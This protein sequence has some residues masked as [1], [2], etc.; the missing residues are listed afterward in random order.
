MSAAQELTAKRKVALRQLLAE[1][2]ETFVKGRAFYQL[3]KP[4]TIQDYKDIIVRRRSDGELITGKE[5]I[6]RGS[7][8]QRVNAA[9]IG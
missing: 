9:Q 5:L 4:E 7:S 3:T 1:H 8:S 6:T 2:G